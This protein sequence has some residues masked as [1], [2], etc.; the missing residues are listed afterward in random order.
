MTESKY[1]VY[2]S[3]F[4]DEIYTVY[5]NKIENG[6]FVFDGSGTYLMSKEQIDFNFIYIGEL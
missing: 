2:Y 3:A 4:M 5:F 1:K 6:Y